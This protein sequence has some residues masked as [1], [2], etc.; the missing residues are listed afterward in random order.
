M[1]MPDTP[2]RGGASRMITDD[3]VERIC[4]RICL[5]PMDRGMWMRLSRSIDQLNNINYYEDLIDAAF[6]YLR[7][8]S[9][10]DSSCQRTLLDDKGTLSSIMEIGTIGSIVHFIANSFSKSFS[11]TKFILCLGILE[12]Y[13]CQLHSIWDGSSPHQWIDGE[14]IFRHSLECLEGNNDSNLFINDFPLL[15]NGI[16]LLIDG[17]IE[18]FSLSEATS[19]LLTA[20]IGPL[21][22]IFLNDKILKKRSL[23][24]LT[25]IRRLLSSCST[26]YSYIPSDRLTV[27]TVRLMDAFYSLNEDFK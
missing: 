22:V 27:G 12:N 6:F 25:K 8:I 15:K 10:D 3:G 2:L 7:E 11:S 17:G 1:E 24:I 21:Y 23:I 20:L 19:P 14:Y 5:D 13:D 9:I 26:F 4:R 16:L 18:N